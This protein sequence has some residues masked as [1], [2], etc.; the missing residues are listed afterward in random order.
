MT[1]KPHKKPEPGDTLVFGKTFTDHMLMVEWTD[2]KGWSQPR[3]QPFQNLSLHPACSALHYSLQVARL[4]AASARFSLHLLPLV[5]SVAG[6]PTLGLLFVCFLLP[7]THHLSS[8]VSHIPGRV[9]GSP[10]SPKLAD[11]VPLPENHM[12]W[13]QASVI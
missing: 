1:Q 9:L 8:E 7:C 2:S 4:T 3:I 6:S 12:F 11:P 10:G 5:L 13:L